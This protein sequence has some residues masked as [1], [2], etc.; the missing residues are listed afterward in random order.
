MEMGSNLA[1]IAQRKLAS[2]RGV[3]VNNV[4]FEDWEPGGAVFDM[5]FAE[6]SWHWLD[7]RVRYAKAAAVLRPAGVLAFTTGGRAF[8]PGFDP[9]FKQIHACYEAIGVDSLKWPPLPP[10][11][12]A[13]AQR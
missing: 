7:P 13:D 3:T 8:P 6:T 10:E 12:I 1:R 11:R 5:V 9:F 4:R 2:F